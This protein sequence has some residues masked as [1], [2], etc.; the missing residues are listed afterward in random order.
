[1]IVVAVVSAYDLIVAQGFPD[2]DWPTVSS[3]LPTWDW[4]AWVILILA[5]LLIAVVEGSYRLHIDNPRTISGKPTQN[6]EEIVSTFAILKREAEN[7]KIIWANDKTPELDTILD[8][9]IIWMKKVIQ[10][11]N[12]MLGTVEDKRIRSETELPLVGEIKDRDFMIQFAHTFHTSKLDVV[13]DRHYRVYNWLGDF[14]KT[15]SLNPDK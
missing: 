15:A 6:T 1:M 4:W 7:L 13:R 14:I 12:R 5:L 3:W 10:D 11:T 8:E 2:S 9:A